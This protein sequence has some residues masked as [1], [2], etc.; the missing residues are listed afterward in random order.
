MSGFLKGLALV[1]VIMLLIWVFMYGGAEGAM[2]AIL[3]IPGKPVP[4]SGFY[5]DPDEIGLLQPDVTKGLL[6]A[7]ADVS[8][9][10]A[11][12]D[13]L[14][15]EKGQL[16]SLPSEE[17]GLTRVAKLYALNERI[18]EAENLLENSRARFSHFLT[19]ADFFGFN[20]KLPDEPANGPTQK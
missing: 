2:K 10:Q 15:A 1:G 7:K 8:L 3:G 9:K 4:W 16:L 14:L 13:E 5:P 19:G 6:S 20:T 17:D 18:D 11:K 12:L